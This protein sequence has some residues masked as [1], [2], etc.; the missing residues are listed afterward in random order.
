MPGNALPIPGTVEGVV[1]K[2]V[3]RLS[4]SWAGSALGI[5]GVAEAVPKGSNKLLGLKK[6]VEARGRDGGQPVSSV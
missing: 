4:A 5:D 1:A 3:T 6:E 2:V